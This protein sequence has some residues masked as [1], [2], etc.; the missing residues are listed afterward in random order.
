MKGQQSL[1]ILLAEDNEVNR[2]LALGLL[3]KYGH[4]VVVAGD[5]YEAIRIIG[6]QPIDLV[7]MDIQMP[8]MDGFAATSA[9]RE[10]ENAT[11]GHIPIIALTAHAMKGDRE[12]CL[13]AGMDAYVSK[14]LRA[15]ELLHAIALLLPAIPAAQIP[16]P[17]PKE[18][19][20]IAD[21]SDPGIFDPGIFDPASALARVEGDRELLLKMVRSFF[22]Q[23]DRVLSEIRAA[24]EHG[25]GKALERAAHKLKGSIGSFGDRRAS[26]TALRLELMGARGELAGAAQALADLETEVTRLREALAAFSGESSPCAF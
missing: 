4:S 15:Q 26:D 9:I 22:A 23:S 8:N 7:L 18:Q 17:G 12:R 3:Q 6:S 19:A 5:G 2:H 1:R 10:R 21:V 20:T 24:V 13:A 25:D 11:G 14:P 16:S